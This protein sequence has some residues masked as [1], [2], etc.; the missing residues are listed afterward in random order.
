MKKYKI[1]ELG[2][3]I[4]GGTPNTGN[5]N[6]WNGDIPWITPKDLSSYNS[7][8]IAHGERYIT[9][10]G[11][12]NSSAKL[13]PKGS[14]LLTSRAPIGYLAIA[15]NELCTNQG[16]KSIICKPEIINYRYLYY[17]LSTKIKELIAT[18]LKSFASNLMAE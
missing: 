11:L 15:S 16:F 8:F 17:L 2:D 13:L 4:S 1:C 6:Y 7:V 12:N 18:A 3:V 5:N 14:V 9:K 10:D